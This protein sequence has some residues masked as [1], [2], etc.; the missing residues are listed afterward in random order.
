MGGAFS[1]WQALRGQ[2]VIA[3]DAT[4][5]AAFGVLLGSVCLG[6]GVQRWQ[7][8]RAA[9]DIVRDGLRPAA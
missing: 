7:P 5:M 1:T 2:S 6:Y 4:T 9:A 3:P 8:G